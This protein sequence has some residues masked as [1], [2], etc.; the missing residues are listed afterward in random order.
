MGTLGHKFK[1][2]REHKNVTLSQAAAVTRLKIQNLE[3]M[4][5]D[6]FSKIPAPAYAKGFI[7]LYAEYLGLDPAPMIKEYVE[8]Y[9]SKARPNKPLED[10]KPVAREPI[11]LPDFKKWLVPVKAF[12]L[13]INWKPY[14]RPAVM[15]LGSILF[16]VVIVKSIRSIASHK[17]VPAPVAEQKA[18]KSETPKRPMTALLMEPGEPYIDLSLSPST[19]P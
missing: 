12:V 11:K 10:V 13:K 17:T 14:L 3:A 19:K 18:V 4:E 5:R 2:A 1:A 7:K 15:V 9:M 8:L 16:V 6:D